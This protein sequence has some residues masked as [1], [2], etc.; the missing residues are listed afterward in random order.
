MSATD[1]RVR[2]AGIKD[3]SVF[4][5]IVLKDQRD[6]PIVNAEIHRAWHEHIAWCEANGK[7]AGILAPWGHGKTEQIVAQ[8]MWRIA[9]NPN[10][11]IKM[12]CNDATSAAERVSEVKRYIENDKDMKRIFRVVPD[13]ESGWQKHQ[14]FVRRKAKSKDATLQAYGILG[15]IIGSR[16]DLLIADDPVDLKNAILQPVSRESVKKAFLNSYS[17]RL[18]SDGFVIYIATIW[19]EDDLTSV[20]LGMEDYS[21]LVMSVNDAMTGIDIRLTNADK[22]HPIFRKAA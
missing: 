17:S 18:E 1:A 8:V 2:R 21:F 9:R 13:E 16:A 12:V 3:C 19:H 22:T 5:E 4:A 10:I 15:T 7:Y 6:R 20:L 11:R 14:I